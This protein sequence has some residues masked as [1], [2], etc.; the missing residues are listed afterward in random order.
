MTV[1]AVSVCSD[2]ADV[3]ADAVVV[4]SDCVLSD[5]VL[6]AVSASELAFCSLLWEP[7]SAAA[8]WVVS[9]D[10]W[11][12]ELVFPPSPLPA[13]L[14][15]S[16]AVV[17]SDEAELSSPLLAVCVVLE[18][19]SVAVSEAVLLPVVCVVSETDAVTEVVLPPSPLPATFWP[20]PVLS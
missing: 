2:V 8:T 19:D 18:V 14:V 7:V 4:S 10:D 20:P 5:G 16:E 1:C 15:V 6:A 11:D 12:S 17:V 13:V 9:E 3:S